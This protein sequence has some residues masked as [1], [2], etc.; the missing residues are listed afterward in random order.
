MPKKYLDSAGLNKFASMV[1]SK[2]AA[3]NHSHSSATTNSAGFMSA[4][5]KVKLDSVSA[6]A[7]KTIVDST[8]SSTSVNAIQNKAVKT[9]L[10]GKASSSHTHSTAQITGLDAAL[11][12]KAPSS[13]NHSADNITSGVLPIGRGGTGATNSVGAASTMLNALVSATEVP[14]D[15]DWYVAKYA[16]D[17]NDTPVRRKHSALWS[18]I[19]AKCD[20]L[21]QPRGSYASSS[22]THTIA[23]VS[24]LQSTLD[25]KASVSHTHSNAT[26]T[27]SGFMSNTDKSKLDGV[28]TGANKT[29][30]DASFSATSTNPVQNKVVK[31]ALDAKAPSSHTHTTSQVSGLDSALAGKAPTSHTHTIAQVTNLQSQL[32]SKVPV[33]RLINKKPLSADM[34]LTPADIGADAAGA[35]TNALNS[36]KQYTD[37]VAAGK[38]AAN[39]SHAWSSITGKPST[40]APSSHSHTSLAYGSRVYVNTDWN[41]IPSGVH[42]VAAKTFDAGK[43][44][45]VEAYPYGTVIVESDGSNINQ[46]YVAHRDGEMWF[47]NRFSS[48]NEF[49]NWEKVST[50]GH[51]HEISQITNLQAQLDGKQP[52]GSYAA[53]SH[54]HAISQI[55]NLQAQLDG[56]Q[57]KGSYA[58]SSHNHDAGN[59]TSGTLSVARGGTGATTGRDAANYFINSLEEGESVPTDADKILTQYVGGGTT[60]TTYVR[61]PLSTLWSYIKPKC[62]AIYQPKGSYAPSSHSHSASNITSGTLPIA[63]GGT[64]A[65]NTIDA[66]YTLRV[67]RCHTGAKLVLIWGMT[68]VNLNVDCTQNIET[69]SSLTNKCGFSVGRYNCSIFCNTSDFTTCPTI[70]AAYTSHDAIGIQATKN[71]HARLNYVIACWQ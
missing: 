25:S 14:S 21:Y 1:L 26:A 52:K 34:T 58:A 64:G 65:N 2:F 53:S 66:A 9:A 31:A 45:P 32:D 49:S 30:V 47:R 42:V 13:H 63:R 4:N 67:P 18:Y 24:N 11:A 57:P 36:A 7:N 40:F 20:G 8:L 54:T 27:A 48:E 39:H 61:R 46:I 29:I 37:T 23:N 19:K 22:H 50:S 62:D 33:G 3:K 10:D 15:D 56:K 12:S 44:A 55:T 69:F 5:D 16:A 35:A 70:H 6:G 41:T 43:H 68:I 59:I 71:G 38:A 28:S 60:N 17:G 51:T